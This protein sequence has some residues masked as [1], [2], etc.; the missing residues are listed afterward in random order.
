MRVFHLDHRAR[1]STHRWQWGGQESVTERDEGELRIRQH[2]FT[3]LD[4][5]QTHRLGR[6][7]AQ[8]SRMSAWLGP[9]HRNDPDCRTGLREK[10]VSDIQGEIAIIT[11]EVGYSQFFVS[12]G[13]VDQKSTFRCDPVRAI[14]AEPVLNLT[15]PEAL[16]D[17]YIP[18]ALGH[19][20]GVDLRTELH[21]IRPGA[22]YRLLAA[23]LHIEQL[24]GTDRM[25]D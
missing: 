1:L 16:D 9:Q 23:H 20:R 4:K 12:I 7:G 19:L 5:G 24:I 13:L 18:Y 25:S 14:A 21:A 2:S 3:V 17:V 10:N 8:Q 11:G 22:L 6:V 15:V